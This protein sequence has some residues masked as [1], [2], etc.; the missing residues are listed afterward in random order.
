MAQLQVATKTRKPAFTS[1]NIVKNG[2]VISY[3]LGIIQL[4]VQSEIVRKI[5]FCLGRKK[6]SS[7]K[8]VYDNL[9]VRISWAPN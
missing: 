9:R 2:K 3:N 4:Y 5:I 1:I 8:R 6:K 7:K